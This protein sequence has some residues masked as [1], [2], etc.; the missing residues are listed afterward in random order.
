[1]TSNLSRKVRRIPLIGAL[2]S[3]VLMAWAPVTDARVTRI[4]VDQTTTPIVGQPL[5]QQLTGR[6]F[7][8]LDPTDPHNT[9]ITDIG[10]APRNANGKVEYIA[11]FRIRKPVD[12]SLASGVM[13]HDVPNRGGDVGFPADSFAANDTQLLSGWQGDNAGGTSVPANV[14]CVPPYVAPCAA[15]AF[16]HHYVKTPV[17]AGV[18]GRILGRIIN[19]SGV[20]AAPLNV[21]GNPIP[22]FPVN[23]NDNAGDTLTIVTNE[24][25]T[26]VVTVG[27][28]VANSDWKYCAGGTFAAP[29]PITATT[30]LP[31]NVCL[32]SPGFD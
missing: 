15:P 6:A 27:G 24:T 4:V 16:P 8:E 7:G 18:T 30:P 10:L 14:S 19:R 2:A 21:M 5:Y 12:M 1:M 17:L 3:A 9:L 32:K 11:S 23:P 22:Y 29:V 13:W 20:N 28:T 25:V 26:G 31:V